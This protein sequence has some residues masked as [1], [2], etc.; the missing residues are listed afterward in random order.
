MAV[1]A[2]K[3]PVA[4]KSRGRPKLQIKKTAIGLQRKADELCIP[5]SRKSVQQRQIGIL[6]SIVKDVRPE[7]V[8][9]DN[10]AGVKE[11]MLQPDDLPS[12]LLNEAVVLDIV[13]PLLTPTAWKKLR[14]A[15]AVHKKAD[16]WKCSCCRKDTGCENCVECDSCLEWYQWQCVGME[17]APKKEW[18]CYACRLLV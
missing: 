10:P 4:S 6:R 2:L 16:I 5:F 12:I 3:F 8:T 13:K 15:F 17:R 18:F 9:A 1:T 14:N 7:D 11:L